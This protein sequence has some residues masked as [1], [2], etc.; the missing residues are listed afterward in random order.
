QRPGIRERIQSDLRTLG[1]LVSLTRFFNRKL[2]RNLNLQGAFDEFRR[3]TLQELDFLREGET[4]KRFRENFADEPAVIFPEIYEPLSTTKVL[5]MQRVGGLRM[6]AAA[7]LFSA[8][9]RKKLSDLIVTTL[10]QMFVRD[11]FFHADLHPGNL[12]FSENASVAMIDVGMYGELSEEQLNRFTIYWLAIV[13]KQKK[14]AF[15]QLLKLADRKSDSREHAFFEY[16]S[17]LLDKFY[18]STIR[19]RSLTQTY[20]EIL[21]AGARFGFVFPSE[22]L[23]QAKALTTA[24]HIGYVFQPDFSFAEVAKPV[25][26]EAFA[27]RLSDDALVQR[28]TSSFPDW[29]LFGET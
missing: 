3:Y 11:G 16:Y 28:L 6:E 10:L 2:F 7:E 4:Y 13:L 22:M 20:L 23:L 24:E 9:L 26:A 17:E 18:N 29:F 5:T 27:D 25:I 19:E 12:F 1:G 15:T 21:I 14:R 8:D